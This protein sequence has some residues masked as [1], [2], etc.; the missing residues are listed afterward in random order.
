MTDERTAVLVMQELSMSVAYIDN[1]QVTYDT[2][3][4]SC[5]HSERCEK[6]ELLNYFNTAFT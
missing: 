6:F 4:K 2:V 1:Q 3:E 5:L